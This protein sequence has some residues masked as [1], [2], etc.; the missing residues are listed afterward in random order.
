MNTK[1]LIEIA[2]KHSSKASMKSSAE[3]CIKDAE[4][5]LE[6]SNDDL[7]NVNAIKSLKYS[8]GIFSPIFQRYAK[9]YNATQKNLCLQF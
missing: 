4:F 2:K 6:N 7:A 8:L 9:E 3:L 5:W 1:K